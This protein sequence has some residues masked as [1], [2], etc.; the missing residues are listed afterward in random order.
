RSRIPRSSG[1]C[2]RHQL[3]EVVGRE[4]GRRHRRAPAVEALGAVPYARRPQLVIDDAV[5]V[6]VVLGEVAGRI[7]QVPEE[8]RADGVSAEPP[9]VTTRIPGEERVRPAADLV[10]VVDLPGRVAE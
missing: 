3:G 6:R 7:P 9:D 10:D 2:R 8:V 4:K 1:V 5:E